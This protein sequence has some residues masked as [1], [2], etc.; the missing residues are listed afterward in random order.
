MSVLDTYGVI[1]LGAIEAMRVPVILALL[2]FVGLSSRLSVE[3]LGEVEGLPGLHSAARHAGTKT[4][5]GLILFRFNA[6]LVS[7]S[8]PYFKSIRSGLAALGIALMRALP[9]ADFRRRG[10]DLDCRLGSVT[11]PPEAGHQG[12]RR[13]A[14]ALSDAALAA[15]AKLAT[16]SRTGYLMP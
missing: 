3:V 15:R 14:T 7:F 4:E 8:A 9:R 1:R 2:R 16:R 5:P 12:R 13:F 6:P 11:G 10:P